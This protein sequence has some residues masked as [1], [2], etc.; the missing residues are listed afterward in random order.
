MPF[1]ASQRSNLRIA[2]TFEDF[3]LNIQVK[4]ISRAAA[5][6]LAF[7][8]A[9]LLCGQAPAAS[10]SATVGP[11]VVKYILT[12]FTINGEAA[13][14][15]THQPLKMDGNWSISKTR[16][17]SCPAT[18]ATCVEVFYAEPAQAAKCSWVVALHDNGTD[19]TIVDENDD[20]AK[21]MLPVVSGSEAKPFVKSRTKP[22][23][24]PIAMAAHVSG[25]VTMWALVSASGDVRK[26]GVVSG[27]PML[28]STAVDAAKKWTFAPMRIA[29][30]TV[31][32]EIQL[33]FT[34]QAVNIGWGIVKTAP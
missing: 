32:Y 16:P 8:G 31:P 15:N 27:P 13:D 9:A 10:P 33:V 4:A 5:A 18:A 21:Y 11:Q 1:I 20:A 6:L 34:F 3:D 14:P 12:H 17:A 2:G 19:G 23:Y 28:Q 30:H 22:V 7:A 29:T 25:T 24:P 26:V